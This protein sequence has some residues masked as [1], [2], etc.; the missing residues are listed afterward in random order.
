MGI[1]F[2]ILGVFGIA[3]AKDLSSVILAGLTL[4][5]FSQVRSRKLASTPSRNRIGQ[6]FLTSYPPEFYERRKQECYNYIFIGITGKRTIAVG[7]GDFQDMLNRGARLRFL[8]LDFEDHAL[9]ESATLSGVSDRRAVH[10]RD[11]IVAS[12][13]DLAELQVRDPEALQVRLLPFLPRIGFNGFSLGRANAE[14]YVQ[15]PIASDDGERSPIYRIEPSDG[16]WLNHFTT[17]VERLWE[18][19]RDSSI[20]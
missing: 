14:L 12:L 20:A 6:V 19:G 17:E 9:I 18:K 4:L 11:A 8:L 10:N 16:Y 7:R 15:H 5:A 3:D 1:V 2:S 13:H